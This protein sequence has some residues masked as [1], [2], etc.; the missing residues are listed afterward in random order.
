V[1]RRAVFLDRDGVLNGT[2]V[3]DGRPRPPVS[4]SHVEVLAGVETACRQLADAGYH[5]IG[6][7][8]QPEIARGTITRQSVEDI[9]LVL[10][11][12]LGLD[13]LRVCPHDDADACRCRKPK[14][15]LLLD[16]ARDFDID[17]VSSI[18][19][20]DRWKDVAAGEAAGCRT[21]FIDHGYDE[22][23]PEN[24]GLTCARLI[25]AVP[26]IVKGEANL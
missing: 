1:A 15:G 19:V 2:V 6:A 8:N 20:G 14:P 26:W 23:R 16:A 7:T 10:I 12:L 17:L 11:E 18:M 4:V 25:D 9:N 13:D 21:V 3:R 24:P 22:Q 5:L